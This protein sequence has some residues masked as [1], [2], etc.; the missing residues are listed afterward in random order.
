[1]STLPQQPPLHPGD[2][3]RFIPDRHHIEIVETCELVLSPVPHWRVVTTWGNNR[4]RIADAAE[5]VM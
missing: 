5:F 4:R 2:L 1:M 3:V